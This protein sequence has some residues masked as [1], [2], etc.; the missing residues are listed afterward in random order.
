MSSPDTAAVPSTATISALP[1]GSARC[2]SGGAP[3]ADES[4]ARI[5]SA[6][7]A[8]PVAGV[9]LASAVPL[10]DFRDDL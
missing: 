5:L 2:N 9:P 8:A 7:N 4:A 6:D 10:L 1:P 3:A